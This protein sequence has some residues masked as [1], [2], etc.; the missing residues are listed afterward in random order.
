[1]TTKGGCK[2]WAYFSRNQQ[3]CSNPDVIQE[4]EMQVH[5]DGLVHLSAYGIENGC[6]A[7]EEVNGGKKSQ[8]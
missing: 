2:N 5:S 6:K 1:M 8:K 3:T 4:N 7:K